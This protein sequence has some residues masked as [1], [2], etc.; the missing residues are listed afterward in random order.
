MQRYRL[1]INED[2]FYLSGEHNILALKAALAAAV[3][4]GGG[5]VDILSSVRSQISLLITSHSVVKFEAIFTED[6]PDLIE[7]TPT[8]GLSYLDDDYGLD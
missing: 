6:L 8:L 2:W 4:N 3:H 7:S 1:T 5:F